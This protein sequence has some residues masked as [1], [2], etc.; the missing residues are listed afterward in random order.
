MNERSLRIPNSIDRPKKI[1]MWDADVFCIAFLSVGFGIL[2]GAKSLLIYT[3]LGLFAAWQW[4]KFKKGKN[5]WFFIH[6][7]YWFL[8]I[9]MKNP[10]IPDTD[11]R[12]FFR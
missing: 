11:K 8:P 9:P 5:P 6:A 2:M 1:F 3:P 12:E 7:L 4:S 10:R